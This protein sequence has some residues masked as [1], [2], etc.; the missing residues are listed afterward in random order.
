MKKIVCMFFAVAFIFLF[1][2]S[3]FAA[4]N[5]PDYYS[6]QLQES[7][8][9]DL[10]DQLP[11]ETRNSLEQ[12]GITG[13]DWQS[14][15]AITPQNLF[16]QV[17][18]MVGGNVKEP[19]RAA[20]SVVA[21][22]LICALLNGMKLSFG[23]RPMSGVIGLVGTLCVTVVVIQP[24]V[25]CIANA[26][27]VIHAAA[28]FLLACVPVLV[29][30]MIAAGQ[31]VS[32]NSY[33]LLMMAAG[34]VISLLSA[35]VLVPLMNIFLAISTVSAVSP[36]LGLGGLCAA[37]HK[38][39]KWAMGFC[40]TIFSGLLT[41]HSVVAASADSA[42]AKAAKFVVSNAVPIV[43]SALG[44]AVQSINACL[45]LLKS[46]VGAFGILAGIFIFLP[47]LVQCTAWIITLHVCSGIGEVFE[48]KEI[49][50]ILKSAGT[51]LE[52]MLSITLCCMAILT[53]S[54]VVILM[55]GGGAS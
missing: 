14:I 24:V 48:Q 28:D 37:F 23:D 33:N 30:I 10:T 19:L 38:V 42:T 16:Q 4:D 54:T 27:N 35:D 15:T 18:S 13:T 9:R 5:Q 43:G 2:L 40:M 1:P 53:V 11:E 47:V 50:L 45:K 6:Q 22:M 46:G 36:N 32:A 17:V 34:N 12:I 39:V 55:I 31:P 41:I 8:A 21:M 52:T 25:S 20:V 26:A 44:D 7:G 49:S 51:V 3:A 29:G